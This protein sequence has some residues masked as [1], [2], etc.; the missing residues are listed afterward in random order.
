MEIHSGT[1]SL[2]ILRRRVLFLHLLLS[3]GIA[4]AWSIG[5]MVGV[6]AAC[7]FASPGALMNRAQPA[8]PTSNP[9]KLTYSKV[10]M[11]S[12]P[13]FVEITVDSSGNGAYEGRKLSEPSNP[14][15]LKLSA[16]STEALFELARELNYFKSIDIESHKKVANLGRK[17]LTYEADGQKNRAEFNYSVRH[18]AQDLADLFEKIGSVEEHIKTLEYE[19]KYDHL[20]LPRELLQIRIDLD[21]K[22]LSNPEL[23]TPALEEIAH[24]P[25]FLH[26]AQARAQLIL[27]RLRENN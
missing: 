14:R 22:A 25:H 11:G 20:S 10:L 1:S 12:T 5:C 8:Q 24:N 6:C 2:Q 18:E 19:S 4:L 7:A 9:A 15:P 27:R 21:N 3:Q 16:A 13:E 17:T 26:L 23:M